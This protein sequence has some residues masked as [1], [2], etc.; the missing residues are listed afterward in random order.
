MRI[1][2]SPAKKMRMDTDTLAPLGLPLFAEEAEHLR[3]FLRAHS[4]AEL[5]TLWDC[6][7]K[8]AAQ[9]MRRLQ[10]MDLRNSL[11]PAILSYDGIQYQY[12]APAVFEDAQLAYVQE[13]L[14]ILSGFYG[15]LRPMDGV[16]PYRLEMQA[17]A[18]VDGHRDLYGFWGDRL[19]R[20]VRDGSRA[21]LNLAS[22]EYARCIETHLQPGDRFVTCVFAEREGGRLIQKGVYV[23]MARGQMVRYLAERGAAEPEACKSFE[24]GGYRFAAELSDEKQFVFVR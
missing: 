17:K 4:A 19:Y 8:I 22:Q 16:T 15:V 12:M 3:D 20:A 23:K 6:S 9:N 14:R 13:H 11:T 10:D 7:E 21:I 18:A 1:I 5:K 2:I 24:G